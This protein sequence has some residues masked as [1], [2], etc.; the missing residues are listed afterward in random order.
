MGLG[1]KDHR[2]EVPFASHHIKGTYYHHDLSLMM[3]TLIKWLKQGSL[4]LSTTTLFS[5]LFHSVLSRRKYY[6]CPTCKGWG[7]MFLF[8]LS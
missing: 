4:G 7:V 1:D 2:G 3:L 6:E 5:L 8:I